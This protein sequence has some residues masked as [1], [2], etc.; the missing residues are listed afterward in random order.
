M[1]ACNIGESQTE[2]NKAVVRNY[3]KEEDQGS[4][5]FVDKYVDPDFV[6]HYPNGA[7]LKGIDKLKN[8][9]KS[10]QSALP[11]GN[12]Q[13]EDQLAEGDK[14][15]TRYTWTGTHKGIYMGIEPTGKQ[16]KFTMLEICQIKNGKIIEG[17]IEFDPSVFNQL[18]E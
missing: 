1:I 8:S 16:L 7:Q 9:V 2:I 15:A 4:K 3:A 5:D 12:H 10:F 6:F 14:V 13:I 18:K 17:W 11:D